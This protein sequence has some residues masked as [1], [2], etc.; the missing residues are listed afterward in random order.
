MG[1]CEKRVLE[2]WY[3]EFTCFFLMH[4]S[5]L[6]VRRADDSSGSSIPRVDLSS[7]D[8]RAVR[9]RLRAHPRSSS[10]WYVSIQDVLK[11]P[12]VTS[13]RFYGPIDERWDDKSWAHRHVMLYLAF[14]VV[15]CW[16][17]ESLNLTGSG[18]PEMKTILRGVVLKEYLTFRTGIAKIVGLTATLGAGM[19]LGKEVS[20]LI[21][22]CLSNSRNQWRL[23][24]NYKLPWRHST[25]VRITNGVFPGPTGAH[26]QRGGHSNVQTGHVVQRHLRKWIAQQRNVGSRLRGRR[27]VQLRRPDRRWFASLHTTLQ[28][29]ERTFFYKT[30]VL[31]SIEVTSVYFAIRNYWR[32]F[33]SAVFGA[34][35]F[36]LMVF[37]LLS[38]RLPFSL[39]NQLIHSS[40][41][42]IGSL[43]K[44][45]DINLL[46]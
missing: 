32:G 3:I 42:L 38:W 9:C 36:R 23:F 29:T 10:N 4:S 37:N 8:S 45:F 14:F 35:M 19:P 17:T 28:L 2:P 30:G 39:A 7:G 20:S 6:A 13:S 11:L 18:I 40:T 41:R 16:V 26:C 21:F 34:L 31:F 27:I 22:Y 5:P 46:N 44:V 15:R 1:A 25:L 12:T 43:K 24:T 33:F